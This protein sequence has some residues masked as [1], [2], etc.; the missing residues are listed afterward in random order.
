MT[1]A[2]YG[3]RASLEPRQIGQPQLKSCGSIL[4]YC[5]HR[6]D[7]LGWLL[8][9]ADKRGSPLDS[10][11]HRYTIDR[12]LDLTATRYRIG[13]IKLTPSPSSALVLLSCMREASRALAV[14]GT[15]VLPNNECTLHAQPSVANPLLTA[16]STA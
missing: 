2:C 4:P 12:S 14:A 15:S 3:L 11:L 6:V 7:A 16:L 13:E 1:Q 9:R 10:I 8:G 5:P